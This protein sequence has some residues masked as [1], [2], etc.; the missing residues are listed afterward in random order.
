MPYQ[1]KPA[2]RPI[3]RPDYERVP[4][5]SSLL[6]L[7]AL[8]FISAPLGAEEIPDRQ[9]IMERD[10]VT[11]LWLMQ[12][13]S[14][15]Y[16]DP[17]TRYTSSYVLRDETVTLDFDGTGWYGGAA[18][19]C[20]MAGNATLRCSD[21]ETYVLASELPEDSLFGKYHNTDNPDLSLSLQKDGNY[22]YNS[23]EGICTYKYE[24][25]DGKVLVYL[26]DCEALGKNSLT[27]TPG[28]KTLECSNGAI[29]EKY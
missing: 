25:K 9:F 6:V 1:S 27:C 11:S 7:T 28:D 21:K 20:S 26:W 12:D 22:F 4:M 2:S 18:L 29:Y 10:Q 5:R 8:L 13:G 16:E 17:M 24:L 14:F 3:P 15:V 19:T 23:P